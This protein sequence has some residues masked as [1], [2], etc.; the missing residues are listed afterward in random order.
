MTIF[1][2]VHQQFFYDDFVSNIKLT[3][4]ENFDT[5]YLIG[6][7]FEGKFNRIKIINIFLKRESNYII[8][9]IT[10]GPR[11]QVRDSPLSLFTTHRR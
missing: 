10:C 2:K 11:T 5:Q 4:I 8:L 7:F 9:S 6:K 1:V 3:K